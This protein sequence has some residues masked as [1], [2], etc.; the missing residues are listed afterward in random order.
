VRLW[1]RHYPLSSVPGGEGLGVRGILFLILILF[2][3]SD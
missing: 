3:F 1:R 2:L